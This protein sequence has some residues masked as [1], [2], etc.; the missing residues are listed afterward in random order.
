MRWRYAAASV[1]GTSHVR[2]GRPGQ[3]AHRCSVKETPDGPVLIVAVSDGAGSAARGGDGSTFICD[4]LVRRLE[5]T[6][7]PQAEVD[8]LEWL[9][10][11][12]AQT[13]GALIAHAEEQELLPR[14]FAATLLCAVLAPQWSVFAQ[15]GDGAIVVSEQ[16]TDEWAWMFWPERGEYANSTTFLTDASALA[17]L[18]VDAMGEGL[19]EVAAFT[20]GL[21]HLVLHYAD[22]AVHSPFFERMF[23]PVRT[24]EV[25][26]E[27]RALSKGLDEYLRSPTVA[28]RADDDL[29][30][31]MA[32][33]RD[34]G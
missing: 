4:D 7:T 30:L 12:I 6:S 28:A 10:D 27:D 21:Q 14:E 19:D 25:S 18:Q 31:V 2:D 32:S 17:S 11:C 15:V 23:G 34:V 5:A 13:R 29:T 16:G 26:G 3:D 8:C 20:D 33:R 24:S 22:Q 9:R 1:E